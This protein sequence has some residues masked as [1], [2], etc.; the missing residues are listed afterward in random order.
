KSPHI[1]QLY[2]SGDEDGTYYYAMEYVPGETLTDRLSREKR[3]PWRDAI[4][5]AVQVCLALKADHNCGIV[6]RD[7][8]PSNLLLHED[9]TV[10]LSDFGV[11]Q[12]FATSRL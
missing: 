7:L 9:G 11:A 2:D 4:D 12:V 5:I 3:I 6:H 8:K 1:V 10:K